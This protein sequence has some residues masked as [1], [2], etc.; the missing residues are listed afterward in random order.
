MFLELGRGGGSTTVWFTKWHWMFT[1]TWFIL[2][3]C[4]L[5]QLKNTSKM[6][7]TS[8]KKHKEGGV[9]IYRMGLF[10]FFP[11]LY[12]LE[13]RGWI[14]MLPHEPYSLWIWNTSINSKNAWSMQK[15]TVTMPRCAVLLQA[16]APWHRSRFLSCFDPQ[17]C[18]VTKPLKTTAPV[19]WICISTRSFS[20][21]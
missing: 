2:C 17:W 4:I 3:M 16:R 12:F 9:T 10:S 19:S 7:F 21:R 15:L 18:L 14:A 20:F 1:L 8:V 6:F 11:P 13:C 5:L